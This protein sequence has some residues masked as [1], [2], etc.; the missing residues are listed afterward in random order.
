MKELPPEAA[1]D[2]ETFRQFGFKSNLTIPLSVGGG[3]PVG[4][5]GFSTRRAECEWPDV[6]VRRLQLVAQIF[7]NAL[8]RKRTEQAL[9]ESE[10]R[11]RLLMEQAPEAILVHDLEENRLVQANVNITERKQTEQEIRDLS[12]RLIRAQEDE[13]R[14]LAR[15][16][17]DDITQRVARMA[18]D[19]G[20]VERGVQDA[21]Q[22]ATMGEVRD[23][24][25]QLSEDIHNLSYHLHPAL[26]DD[27]GLVEALRAEGG[28][29]TKRESV[30]VEIKCRDVPDLVPQ[31]PALCLFRV[32]QEALHN[33][34]RHSRARK[35][36]LS[37]RG[38]DSGLQLAVRDDG[39]GFDPALS[40]ER[41]SLGLASMRERVR[42][43]D[44]ELDVESA[45]GHGTTI[46][47]W[48]PLET[49]EG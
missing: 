26:L 18:I 14:R 7:A 47:A 31:A 11:F 36:E 43:L 32:A 25:I 24:L 15:E 10:E 21:R 35:V 46:V 38:L 42:L 17:H 5:L 16:L 1:R 48:V 40:R 6:L 20:R 28:R 30:P 13:R 44:G 49:G 37:L 9:R 2:R 39:C 23:G 12:G 45:P 3:P 19:V 33:A 29:F 41:P 4:A 34:G 22:A 27:L 8:A